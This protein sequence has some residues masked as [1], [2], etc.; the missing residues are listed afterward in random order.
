MELVFIQLA[1]ILFTAFVVSY[2]VRTFNQPIIIGYIITG[3]IIS[4]FIIS[5]GASKEIISIFSDFGIAFLLFIVGLHMNPKVIKEIGTSALLIGLAQIIL[6][7]LL[8]FLVSLNLLGFDTITSSYIGIAL[9]FS[10]TIIIMKLL[11]DKKQ[12]DSLYGKISIGILIIQD[13]VAIAVL[14]FISSLSNG[15]SFSS[16]AV[17]GLLAGGILILI[18]FFIGFFILPTITRNIA[19]SQELLFLFSITW[20]FLIAALFSYFGFSIEIGA[21]LAGIVLSISPYSIEISSKI[22]PLRDFFL[23]IFFIILGLNI[24]VSSINSIIVNALILSALALIFK[25]LILITLMMMF[26]YTKRTNFLL[27]TTLGQISEFSLIV[28]ALGLTMGHISPEVL[29]TLTLTGI[30]TITLSTYMIIYSTKFYD[31]MSNIISIFERKRVRKEIKPKK[32]YEAILFGYNRIGFGILNS[33]KR[34]RKNYLVV[35]F[36]PDTISDLTKLRIPSIYGDI[37]DAG[38][39]EELP[40]DK[41]QLIVSTIPDFE[42]NNLLIETIREENKDAIIIVRAHHIKEALDLY[43]KG[44]NYVL[45]PYFL[46]GEYV[47]KMI[48]EAKIDDRKYKEEKE[49]HVKMLKERMKKGHEQ[50][51]IEKN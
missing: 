12:L 14:M 28:L 38:F 13:L 21:L 11:S 33:F 48:G 29:S 27:G 20:C 36:N 51:E 40:L 8:G 31:K 46:G 7:F 49:K 34:I 17:R 10:S 32:K 6:T 23:V 35:D 26:G 41:A 39:L 37:Y 9:A 19:R 42:T 15:T 47:S 1:I 18:L 22:R 50:L 16:F 2:I 24:Q 30:I 25:P 5:F 45:T 43:R 4:P 44:A 3:I